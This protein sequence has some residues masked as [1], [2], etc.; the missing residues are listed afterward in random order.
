VKY[1]RHICDLLVHVLDAKQH[2]FSLIE[3]DFVIGIASLEFFEKFWQTKYR[4]D[5]IFFS[6]F[7]Q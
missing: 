5:R 2:F 7:Y 6:G 1:W 3:L 4:L